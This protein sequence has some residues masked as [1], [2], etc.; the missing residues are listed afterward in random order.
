MVVSDIQEIA[1]SQSLDAEGVL[2]TTYG[3]ERERLLAS[4]RGSQ[5]RALCLLLRELCCV[6][7]T[8]LYLPSGARSH[9]SVQPR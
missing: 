3:W 1:R 7:Q 8:H 2:R 9:G 4:M 5:L 6:P